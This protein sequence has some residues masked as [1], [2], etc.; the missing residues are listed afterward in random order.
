MVKKPITLR[1]AGTQELTNERLISMAFNLTSKS[2]AITLGVAYDPTDTES[3]TQGSEG[4][5]SGGFG[6]FS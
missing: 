2:N 1:A 4:C 6:W 5:V 3:N